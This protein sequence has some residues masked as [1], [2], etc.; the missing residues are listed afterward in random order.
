[1]IDPKM[2]Q[3]IATGVG[4]IAALAQIGGSTRG[5]LKGF[6]VGEDAY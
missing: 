2:L 3:D 6:G 1:M 5:A 4:F